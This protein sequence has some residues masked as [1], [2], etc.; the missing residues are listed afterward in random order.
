[1]A[2]AGAGDEVAAGVE[3]GEPRGEEGGVCPLPL[4]A[5]HPRDDVSLGNVGSIDGGAR[6][7][8][9]CEGG[10]LRLNVER[11]AGRREERGNRTVLAAVVGAAAVREVEMRVASGATTVSPNARTIGTVGVDASLVG[12]VVEGDPCDRLLAIAS[13]N[14]Q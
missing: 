4:G 3:L 8:G 5:A 14:L 13:R 12:I 10:V 9:R 2:A 7:P 11:D 1:M 6:P